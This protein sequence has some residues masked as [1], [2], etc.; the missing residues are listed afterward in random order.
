MS[1]R[2][3]LPVVYFVDCSTTAAMLSHMDEI[4]VGHKY[5]D[6]EEP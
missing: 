2:H 5:S 3:G 1:R 4:E 6:R